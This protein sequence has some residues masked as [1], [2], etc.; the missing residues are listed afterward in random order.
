MNKEDKATFV[1]YYVYI[2]TIIA[3][4]ILWYYTGKY[5]GQQEVWQAG[6]QKGHVSVTVDDGEFN[7]EWK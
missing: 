7:F 1:V 2:L 3:V 6:Y 5:K 4:S